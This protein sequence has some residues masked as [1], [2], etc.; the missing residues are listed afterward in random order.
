MLLFRTT[1]I[2]SI[3]NQLMR[4]CDVL[5]EQVKQSKEEAELLMQAVLREVLEGKEV[6]DAELHITKCNYYLR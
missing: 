2:V 6:S 5:E 3:V 1:Q 4:L